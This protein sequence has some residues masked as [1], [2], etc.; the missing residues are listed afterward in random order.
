LRWFRTALLSLAGLAE[1]D[2]DFTFVEAKV[3]RRGL[4]EL[5]AI[6]AASTYAL[7]RA[8]IALL[9]LRARIPTPQVISVGDTLLDDCQTIREA[10]ALAGSEATISVAEG[11]YRESLVV[12][13]GVKIVPVRGHRVEIAPTHGPA[14]TVVGGDPLIRNLVL[15]VAPTPAPGE[16]LPP[17]AIHVTGGKPTVRDCEI[18]GS[19]G[20]GVW[21]SGA[22][23]AATVVGTVI[24]GPQGKC[25]TDEPAG[26]GVRFGDGT[27][28]TVK[29][30]VIKPSGAAWIGIHVGDGVNPEIIETKVTSESGGTGVHVGPGGGGTFL[31][32]TVTAGVGIAVDRGN[33]TVRA[34]QFESCFLGLKVIGSGGGT[35]EECAFDGWSPAVELMDEA[36]PVL[37]R[38]KVYGRSLAIAMHAGADPMVRQ[39]A[40]DARSGQAIVA[41]DGAQGRFE[42]CAI[43]G[44]SAQPIDQW[45][46]DPTVAIVSVGARTSTQFVGCTIAFG[47]GPGVAVAPS[48]GG[49][50]EDC[51]IH[52]HV[53][54]GITVGLGA[55]PVVHG[56][57]IASNG[58]DGVRVLGG[59]RGTFEGCTVDGNRASGLR[60]EAGGDPF[61]RGCVITTNTHHGVSVNAGAV[62]RIADC[63]LRGNGAGD[64]FVDSDARVQLS[65]N[66]PSPA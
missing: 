16:S 9:A 46:A 5:L 31:K 21:V 38:C 48:G 55:H 39:T 40:I 28:G 7:Y 42:Q 36:S 47:P 19:G 45:R 52:D 27:G 43:G 60:I 12:R 30:C 13:N 56:G 34:S 6:G 50:F 44:T 11:T 64:W 8:P 25:R 49:I 2:E 3:T 18:Y 61:V 10:L 29:K 53:G 59:G 22:G 35:Y 24:H 33:P 15:R 41:K 66:D 26:A 1:W 57:S 37:D 4:A 32:C 23:T 54:P 20:D 65:R 14:I 58:G 63:T 17:P 62:G 51:K